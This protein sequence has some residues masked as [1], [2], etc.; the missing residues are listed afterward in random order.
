M[1]EDD[2]IQ[3]LNEKYDEGYRDACNEKQIIIDDLYELIEDIETR[4]A[5]MRRMVY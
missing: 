4:I 5:S 2:I 1:L 3:Q